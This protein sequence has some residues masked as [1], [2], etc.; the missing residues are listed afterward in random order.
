MDLTPLLN[1][2]WIQ[3][4]KV[5]FYG[6]EFVYTGYGNSATTLAFFVRQQ[7]LCA[8]D[9]SSNLIGRP[10]CHGAGKLK[11]WLI[12]DAMINGC[13]DLPPNACGFSLKWI[14]SLYFN[15]R[16]RSTLVI[17]HTLMKKSAWTFGGVCND[18]L[19]FRAFLNQFK[20]SQIQT[21]FLNAVFFPLIFL[22]SFL[23]GQTKLY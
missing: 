22:E 10:F 3:L 2:K 1:I 17:I 7:L 4:N 13:R 15:S 16:R 21:F 9:P 20:F 19:I 12:R 8:R 23:N 18:E 14:L 6:K 5:C 11:N